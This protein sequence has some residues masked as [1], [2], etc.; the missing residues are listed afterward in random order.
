MCRS[1]PALN[2]RRRC[3]IAFWWPLRALRELERHLSSW[4]ML[5]HLGLRFGTPIT[6]QLGVQTEDRR[7]CPGQIGRDAA[8]ASCGCRTLQAGCATAVSAAIPHVIV[9]A[10]IER[11]T[12]GWFVNDF[13]DASTNCS[14]FNDE[15]IILNWFLI[16]STEFGRHVPA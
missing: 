12:G 4:L 11:I 6:E 16:E 1:L 2:W 7:R 9:R 10:G 14:A 3:G 13:V 8:F 5:K 15:P